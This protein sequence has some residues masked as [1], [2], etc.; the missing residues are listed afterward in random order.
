MNK[1]I[2]R[3]RAII[4]ILICMMIFTA[5]GCSAKD[6]KKSTSSNSSTSQNDKAA[7]TKADN[8]TDTTTD[9]KANNT[10]DTK[11]NA[12]T[13]PKVNTTTGTS[14]A[15]DL[16][17]VP[18]KIVYFNKGKQ[19]VIDKKNKKFDKIVKLVRARVTS[20]ND[21][22]K[23]S[24]TSREIEKQ[25]KSNNVVEFIYTSKVTMNWKYGKDNKSDCKL[26][27]NSIVFPL[28]GQYSKMAIFT[29]TSAGPIGPLKDPK[30][31]L[32][33]IKN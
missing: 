16:I 17:K 7:E 25:E 10:T 29:P 22:Y 12:P 30:E 9:T 3:T 28:D 14:D 26:V 21:I 20:A 15:E 4:S 18:D 8:K 5:Y 13:A 11:V 24:M 19:T 27:Y 1:S 33:Y 2:I 23:T 31:L 32:N 6:S